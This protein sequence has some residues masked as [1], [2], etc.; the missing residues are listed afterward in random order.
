MPFKLTH[1][2]SPQC[3]SC[4]DGSH[5][6]TSPARP[7]PWSPPV[8][9]RLYSSSALKDREETGCP[10]YF[11]VKNAWPS[12]HLFKGKEGT[13]PTTQTPAF[14]GMLG[15]LYTNWTWGMSNCRVQWV[16]ADADSVLLQRLDPESQAAS[17]HH[18]ACLHHG[19]LGKSTFMKYQHWQRLGDLWLYPEVDVSPPVFLSGVSRQV[20]QTDCWIC[21]NPIGLLLYTFFVVFEITQQ[22]DDLNS[23]LKTSLEMCW[24]SFSESLLK[25]DHSFHTPSSVSVLMTLPGRSESCSFSVSLAKMQPAFL[26]HLSLCH[27]LP[28]LP[29]RNCFSSHLRVVS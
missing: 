14:P 18:P 19:S 24:L 6:S 11:R 17:I 27:L 5:I 20:F 12:G 28:V 26:N 4:K 2:K 16:L 22:W 8:L 23:T 10:Q 21:L 3:C 13:F 15:L 1:E 29:E 25:T 7:R 9:P